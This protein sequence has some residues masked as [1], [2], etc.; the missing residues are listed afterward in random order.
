[1]K[2]KIWQLAGAGAAIVIGMLVFWAGSNYSGQRE[3]EMTTVM[4]QSAV[5]SQDEIITDMD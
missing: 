4:P 5:L 3:E 1:M 2:R